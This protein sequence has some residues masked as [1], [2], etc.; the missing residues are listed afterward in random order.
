MASAHVLPGRPAPPTGQGAGVLSWL[1][2]RRG[3]GRREI[4]PAGKA[5]GLWDSG[6]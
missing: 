1:L 5:N 6:S 3:R 4:Y 2:G